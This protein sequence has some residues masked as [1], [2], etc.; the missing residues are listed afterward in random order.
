MKSSKNTVLITV[1]GTVVYNRCI[2]IHNGPTLI[3]D[4]L[5]GWLENGEQVF[6]WIRG[7]KGATI[8][9]IEIFFHVEHLL[10]E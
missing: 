6:F 9:H 2:R 8:W 4:N 1:F 3:C 5:V 10:S 7:F